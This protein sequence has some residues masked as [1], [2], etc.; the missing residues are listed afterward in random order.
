MITLIRYCYLILQTRTLEI[1]R[2][3]CGMWKLPENVL[4]ATV[5]EALERFLNDRLKKIAEK[6]HLEIKARFRDSCRMKAK[7]FTMR[8]LREKCR[9]E[10]QPLLNIIHS[11]Y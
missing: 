3:D 11:Y 5:I 2:P 9:E 10:I 4:L 6:I 7:V 1:D 8:N